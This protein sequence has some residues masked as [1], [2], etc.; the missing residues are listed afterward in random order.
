[1]TAR[2]ERFRLLRRVVSAGVIATTLLAV[3]QAEMPL[4]E[5]LQAMD[6][7]HLAQS[8]N[9][10]TRYFFRG[11]EVSKDS[12]YAAMKAHAMN[13][14]LVLSK[15][16]PTEMH[17]EVVPDRGFAANLGEA[18]PAVNPLWSIPSGDHKIYNLQANA[19]GRVT[20]RS[21]AKPGS[22]ESVLDSLTANAIN[23]MTG[24]STQLEKPTAKST[25]QDTIP[26]KKVAPPK[27]VVKKP[28][29]RRKVNKD[30]VPLVIYNKGVARKVR[31]TEV[32]DTIEYA[33]R[34]RL[35]ADSL[36]A[37]E[38]IRS[39]RITTE[40][41]PVR[42]IY[43]RN[44]VVKD[45]ATGMVIVADSMEMRGDSIVTFKAG[46]SRIRIRG[47]NSLHLNNGPLIILNGV[48]TEGDVSDIDP[49]SIE[50]VEVIKGAAA[51][52]LYGVRAANGI[53]RITTKR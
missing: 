5:P 29:A 7:S 41:E 21:R 28:V 16:A 24:A 36:L 25:V 4:P 52:A 10:T 12:A 33:K 51:T 13:A 26:R 8:A 27:V 32:I 34:V 22:K 30:T 11:K 53:I 19:S 46:D 45:S 15:G 14:T 17:L 39:G 6:A 9:D 48:I 38:L 42:Y 43:G 47:Q 50:N 37:I 23:E 40:R 20:Y 35:A 44:V 18:S 1:M 2:P 49:K 3:S 31:P